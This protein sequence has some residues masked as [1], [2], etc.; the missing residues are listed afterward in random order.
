MSPVDV[1]VLSLQVR[2]PSRTCQRAGFCAGFPST[3]AQTTPALVR[4]YTSTN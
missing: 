2:A 4:E 3:A 1:N